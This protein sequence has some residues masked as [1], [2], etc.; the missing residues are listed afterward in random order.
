MLIIVNIFIYFF[1]KVKIRVFEAVY[2]YCFCVRFS[3][4][5]FI[6]VYNEFFIIIF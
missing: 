2:V 6:G 3:I 1:G 5:I 4:I